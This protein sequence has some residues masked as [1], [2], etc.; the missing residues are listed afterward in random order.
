MKFLLIISLITLLSIDKLHAREV[1]DYST[2][3][4]I[5]CY[6][7]HLKVLK[8]IESNFPELQTRNT[9]TDCELRIKNVKTEIFKAVK[10]RMRKSK[11]TAPIADCIVDYLKAEYWAE[12]QMKHAIYD[13]SALSDDVKKQKIDEVR[14]L[15]DYESELASKYCSYEDELGILYDDFYD[16]EGDTEDDKVTLYCTRKYVIDN[17]LL[18]IQSANLTLDP[19]VEVAT[20][21]CDD[22][23]DTFIKDTED[24][25]TENLREEKPDVT[26]EQIDCTLQKYRNGKYTEKIIE[27]AVVARINLSSEEKSK[28]RRNFIKFIS[29]VINEVTKCFSDQN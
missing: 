26:N 23:I 4:L 6:I 15:S 21:D 12:I 29:V 18:N 27:T 13:A 8:R 28:H 22:I 3:S 16:N 7:R 10:T 2:Q 20:K 19:D 24:S 25:L 14:Q 5:N 1:I 11:K 17:G 9:I